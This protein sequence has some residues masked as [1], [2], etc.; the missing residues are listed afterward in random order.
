[1]AHVGIQD[2][3]VTIFNGVKIEQN[4]KY[5]S[6]F[7]DM[8][9]IKNRYQKVAIYIGRLSEEKG[10][11]ILL[12]AWRE[13]VK[14]EPQ[15]G[16]I[17]VGD[18]P[19]RSKLFKY[20]EENEM[21]GNVIFA[22]E[23]RDVTSC[24]RGCDI[25]ILPSRGEGISN[26]LLEA[27]ANGLPCIVSMVGGNLKLIKHGETGM[28]FEKEDPEGLMHCITELL[29]DKDMAFKLGNNAKELIKREFSIEV[30]ANQYL[31]LYSKLL[32]QR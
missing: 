29:H 30:I 2:N 28:I 12:Q 3:V 10:V 4:E 20:V 27:M 19:Q 23:R 1:M 6:D 21:T 5:E 17:I 7:P 13:V 18:G 32:G 11:D 14:K 8:Q 25:F 9:N 22:G 31:E 26:A 15:V 16:L 24:L